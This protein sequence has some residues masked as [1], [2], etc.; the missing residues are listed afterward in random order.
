MSLLDTLAGLTT[1]YGSAPIEIKVE[2]QALEAQGAPNAVVSY[3]ETVSRDV[4]A[5][6]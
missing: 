1:V 2:S 3:A 4:P 5:R 6:R